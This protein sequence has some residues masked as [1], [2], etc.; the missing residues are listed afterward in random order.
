[1]IFRILTRA[2]IYADA[3]GL[4]TAAICFYPTSLLLGL[5]KKIGGIGGPTF[6]RDGFSDSIFGWVVVDDLI[7]LGRHSQLHIFRRVTAGPPVIPIF[8]I[9]VQFENSL[10][11]LNHQ[12]EVRWRA[13]SYYD[14]SLQSNLSQQLNILHLN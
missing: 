10:K 13:A 3:A 7:E 4:D 11:C 9:L 14:H 2:G 6:H 1:M 12:S 8:T 5:V